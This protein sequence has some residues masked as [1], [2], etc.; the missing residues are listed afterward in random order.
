MNQIGIWSC[1]FWATYSVG[2][3]SS[4]SSTLQDVSSIFPAPGVRVQ[5]LQSEREQ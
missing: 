2:S 1:R 5:T 4:P 3:S